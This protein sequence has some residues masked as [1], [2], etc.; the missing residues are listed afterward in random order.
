MKELIFK[1][2]N[3]SL[4]KSNN[5]RNEKNLKDELSL[6]CPDLSNQ[7]SSFKIDM[8]DDYLVNK[9]RGQHAFQISLALKAVDL[10]KNKKNLNIVDI[11]DSSGTHIT[12]LKSILSKGSFEN[13]RTLSVDI[14]PVAVKKIKD[15]GLDA[16]CCRAEELH[17]INDGV[18]A[19]LFLMYEALEHFFNPIGF[20]HD[21]S[22]KSKCEY[23]V[24]T[25]PYVKN[26]RVGL[27]Q[28]RHNSERVM[29]AESTHIFELS[30][31][32]WD[33]LFKFSG[34]EIVYRDKYLQYPKSFPLNMTKYIWRKFDF[35]GF[36]GV[37][38]K[39]N[40]KYSKKYLDW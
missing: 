38:L 36:Y 19:D 6:I 25:I 30:P 11:G 8:S 29:N 37:V 18:E 9:V 12:Y 2:L 35:E 1:I 16:I 24:I 34:W 27:H 23:F 39:K 32:D 20:L 3:Y 31:E 21:M 17:L 10:L 40:L 28:L 15:K 7:Y 13:L 4:I 5:S 26:S 33:W 22:V 14:D